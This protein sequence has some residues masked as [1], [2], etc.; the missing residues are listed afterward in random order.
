MIYTTSKE[1]RATALQDIV[2]VVKHLERDGGQGSRTM[3]IMLGAAMSEIA[4]DYAW[5]N[6]WDALARQELLRL[7]R[8]G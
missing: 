7:E 1:R 5:Y 6:A 2:R 4:G 3:A 8:E